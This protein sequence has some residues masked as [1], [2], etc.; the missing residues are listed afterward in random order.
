VRTFLELVHVGQDL[1]LEEAWRDHRMDNPSSFTEASI[2]V[3]RLL[4]LHPELVTTTEYSA[5]I[6]PCERCQNYG[7]FRCA[8]P[9]QV[10]EIL[11]YW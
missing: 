2:D 4:T 3:R 1:T 9:A 5:A 7:R 10:V 6:T 8:P 11:G